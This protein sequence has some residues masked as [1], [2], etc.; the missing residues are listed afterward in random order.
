MLKDTEFT[1]GISFDE[2]P[3]EDEEPDEIR[4]YDT[5]GNEVAINDAE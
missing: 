5:A 1:R 3:F 4:F 2:D